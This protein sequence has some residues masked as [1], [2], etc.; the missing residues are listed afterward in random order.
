MHYIYKWRVQF[1]VSKNEFLVKMKQQL[2]YYKFTRGS[3]Q[4]KRLWQYDL[5]LHHLTENLVT[6]F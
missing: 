6:S 5:K 1:L 2:P 3:H 4:N